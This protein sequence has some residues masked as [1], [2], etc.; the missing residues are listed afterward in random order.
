MPE[1]TTR[2]VRFDWPLAGKAFEVSVAP[3]YAL[4]AGG[5][6]DI[7]NIR[8]VVVSAYGS[9]PIWAG[10]TAEIE[11]GI[12]ERVEAR[13][14]DPSARF[15]VAEYEDR[16][17][18]MNGVALASDTK[19]NFLTGICVAPDHQG[20]GLGAALLGHSLSW[21]RDQGLALATVTTDK[22]AV[23]AHV[24]RRFDARRVDNTEYPG[25]F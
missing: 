7:Q 21:L 24:Y 14:T 4:R 22:A 11:T 20:R 23:A 17:V 3:G 25:S 5:M 2:W 10:K 1:H 15:V 16:I 8:D 18:G 19:M 12:M 6:A 13:I 9:D